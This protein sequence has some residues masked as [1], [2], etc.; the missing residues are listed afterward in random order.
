MI[1]PVVAPS[2]LNRYVVAIDK[3]PQ[4]SAR[5]LDVDRCIKLEIDRR[6]E[7]DALS[8]LAPAA[9]FDIRVT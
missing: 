2:P 3:I 5:A 8:R 4:P 7:V 1:S 6:I 9:Y